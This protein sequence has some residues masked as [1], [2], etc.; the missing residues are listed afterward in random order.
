MNVFQ[1][2]TANFNIA[3]CNYFCTNLIMCDRDMIKFSFGGSML[4]RKGRKFM[5]SKARERYMLR[6]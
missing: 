2:Q 3:K 6:K 5:G 4:A 1:H